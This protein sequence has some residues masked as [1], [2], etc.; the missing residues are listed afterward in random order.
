MQQRETT[1][2]RRFAHVAYVVQTAVESLL[3]SSAG[4]AEKA[5]GH[6]NTFQRGNQNVSVTTMA[7]KEERSNPVF[8]GFLKEHEAIWSDNTESQRY[9]FIPLECMD[10]NRRSFQILVLYTTR[11]CRLSMCN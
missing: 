8:A 9:T 7:R 3:A 2:R 1:Q 10:I 11:C 4:E 6:R 5:S